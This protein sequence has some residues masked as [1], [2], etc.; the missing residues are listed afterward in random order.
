MPSQIIAYQTLHGEE[1]VGALLDDGSVRRLPGT[2]ANLPEVVA[3]WAD[4]P[5]LGPEGQPEEELAQRLAPVAAQSRVF[6]VAQNYPAHA[7]E[8]GGD[9]PPVPIIFLKPSTAFVG[10]GA[11]IRADDSTLLLD[12]E[13]ELGVVIG[14]RGR[15]STEDEAWGMIAGF[16]LA[17]EGSARALQ[18]ATLAGQFQVDWFS[19]KSIDA[20]SALG[21]AL[22]HA[23]A[24]PQRPSFH[25][26][27]RL[28]GETVQDDSTLSM[29]HSI[30]DL[31]VYISRLVELLPGD[32]ILTGTPAGVGKA[33]GRYPG[34]GDEFSIE[35]DGIAA[36][37]NT[38]RAFDT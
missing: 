21:P 18:P 20:S 26:V 3:R 15:A 23:S 34:D 16:T 2:K 29:F 8:A 5:S 4:A 14:S 11:T 12:Y 30:P 1:R 38:Y 27:A 37:V 31:I 13:A 17:N 22:V 33:R 36:L 24:F 7:A 6:C 28:N 10:T 25:L 9:S 32:I 35:A 19:A